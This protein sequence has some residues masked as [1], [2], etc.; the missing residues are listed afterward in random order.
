MRPLA[1]FTI[2]S[3]GGSTFAE[4]PER[5]APDARILWHAELDP[6]TLPVIS[7]RSG[8]D[9]AEAIDPAELAPWLTVAADP[10]GGEHAVLSDG[11][12]HI[13]L[14]VEVGSLIAPGPVVLHYRL[15]GISTAARR[16][17]PL[18]RLLHFFRHRRFAATLYPVDPR[19]DRFILLLRVSDGLAAGA[20]H[21]EIAR[22]VFGQER[23][24]RQWD[25]SS[26]ALRSQV[27]RLVV[28]ARAMAA[29]GYRQMLSG[30]R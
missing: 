19:M 13:R 11:L 5:A 4:N 24:D 7:E 1:R 23:V 2:L 18:R 9:A 27:R 30:S 28:D 16:I 12:H 25:G 3:N 17:L 10:A 26:D 6:G 20:S 21:R 29:G 14:D 15:S 22:V 8:P